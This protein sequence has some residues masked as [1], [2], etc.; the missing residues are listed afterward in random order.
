MEKAEGLTRME[1]E[2]SAAKKRRADYDRLTGLYNRNGF[3]QR[4]EK[5]LQSGPGGGGASIV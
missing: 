5:Y 4:A 1:G 3:E 2:L